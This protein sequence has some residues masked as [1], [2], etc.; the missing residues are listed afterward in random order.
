MSQLCLSQVTRSRTEGELQW[1]GPTSS[2]KVQKEII[3]I[4]NSGC[5]NLLDLLE[6]LKLDKKV[7]KKN[8]KNHR[9][10]IHV[11]HHSQ[12]K[13]GKQHRKIQIL[14]RAG[15]LATWKESCAR[16][17]LASLLPTD[18]LP[19]RSFVSLLWLRRNWS[20]YQN[21][22]VDKPTKTPDASEPFRRI[23][24]TSSFQSSCNKVVIQEQ[25]GPSINI[26]IINRIP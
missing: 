20:F 24:I 8:M 12:T 14:E 15:L 10:L 26:N 23:K 21:P 11:H 17:T 25:V 2:Q 5:S 1:C 7:W 16:C 13:F 4:Q 22:G 19:Y 3:G 18:F 6:V 9:R